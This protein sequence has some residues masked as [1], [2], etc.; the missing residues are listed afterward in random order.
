LPDWTTSSVHRYEYHI[1]PAE[2]LAAHSPCRRPWTIHPSCTPPFASRTSTP[3]PCGRP[4]PSVGPRKVKVSSPQS[5]SLQPLISAARG[6]G[7]GGGEGAGEDSGAPFVFNRGVRPWLRAM[8]WKMNGGVFECGSDGAAAVRFEVCVALL[9]R[10][11][12]A[13]FVG[14]NASRVVTTVPQ[15]KSSTRTFRNSKIKR[16]PT[17]TGM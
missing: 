3:R 14:S 11:C 13:L 8:E 2:V 1:V 10:V 7:E 15:R 5:G 17:C 9:E 6:G 4:S 16:E 12:A